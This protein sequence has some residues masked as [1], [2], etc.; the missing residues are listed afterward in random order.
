MLQKLQKM[1]LQKN[2]IESLPSAI[3]NCKALKV[4]DVSSNRLETFPDELLLLKLNEFYFESNPLLLC[5][6]VP[7]EQQPVVLPLQ[8]QQ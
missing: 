5:I 2:V 3:G 7:S 8:V 1:F 4:L 6:P